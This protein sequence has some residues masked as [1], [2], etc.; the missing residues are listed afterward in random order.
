MLQLWPQT[1]KNKSILICST[2]RKTIFESTLVN[3]NLKTNLITVMATW[4]K[5]NYQLD[6]F[7]GNKSAF[8]LEELPTWKNFFYVF[9]KLDWSW[10]IWEHIN[11]L[12]QS[13]TLKKTGILRFLKN[14]PNQSSFSFCD[15][16]LEKLDWLTWKNLKKLDSFFGTFF[17]FT[18]GICDKLDWFNL[19]RTIYT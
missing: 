13:Q 11:M 14:D 16:K 5:V 19:K 4:K 8:A 15:C 12:Y 18:S 7:F 2:S 17:A 6:W 10:L 9:P 3:S 1:W